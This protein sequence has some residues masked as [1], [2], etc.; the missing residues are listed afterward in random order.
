LTVVIVAS[1]SGKLRPT[2]NC[3]HRVGGEVVQIFDELQ[4]E[5]FSENEFYLLYFRDG[6]EVTDTYHGTFDAA[7][8]QAEFEFGITLDDWKFRQ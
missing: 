3:T 4:I 6:N 8:E 7:L 1:Y 5:K 2:G